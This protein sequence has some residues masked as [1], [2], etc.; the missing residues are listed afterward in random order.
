MTKV[1]FKN[2]PI[3]ELVIGVYFGRDLP[4]FGV[5][6]IGLFW[7]RIRD[8]FPTVSQQ[9]I[10]T[11]PGSGVSLMIEFTSEQFPMPRFWFE[12]AD[13]VTLIQ[14]Q[15]DA[16]LFNWRKRDAS[17][18][19]FETV[20]AGF[21]K[22]LSIFLEF[23]A[24]DVLTAPDFRIAELTYINAL[25]QNEYWSGPRDTAAV[26]PFFRLP[27]VDDGEALPPDFHQVSTQRLAPDLTLS[28]TVR[29]AR[30][31]KD[32]TKPALVF[33]LRAVGTLNEA[34]R[35]DLDRWF[36]RAHDTTGACFLSMTSPDIQKRYWEP[37]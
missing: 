37:V 27:V 28:T 9:P 22:Y 4:S 34:T 10:V 26:L 18:P 21:D 7:A 1:K 31:T 23:L 19:H 13:G 3:S 36:D 29:S 30:A 11:P 14:V 15:K 33:E 12:A 5:E 16:F 24:R 2:P 6:H 8:E 20:K 17:Y 25:F 35:V 32:A